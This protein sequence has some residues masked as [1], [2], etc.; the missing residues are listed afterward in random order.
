MP[1][2]TYRCADCAHEYDEF[3]PMKAEPDTVCPSCQG[4]VDR[5][6]GAGAGILFKGSGFYVTDYVRKDGGKESNAGEESASDT[7]DPK[8]SSASDSTSDKSESKASSPES[9]ASSPPS[10]SSGNDSNSG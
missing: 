5:L 10:G 1:T 3:Q 8:T 9:G 2:Y 6:I 7:A 4:R